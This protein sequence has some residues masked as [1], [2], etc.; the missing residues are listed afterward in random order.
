MWAGGAIQRAWGQSACGQCLKFNHPQH[1]WALV[2]AFVIMSMPKRWENKAITCCLYFRVNLLWSCVLS[3]GLINGCWRE[4][5][6]WPLKRKR[7]TCRSPAVHKCCCSKGIGTISFLLSQKAPQQINRESFPARACT[8]PPQ[9]AIP[10]F[11][12][13]P[14]K[15]SQLICPNKNH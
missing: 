10:K 4:L 5:R 8:K 14:S 13:L 11:L 15:G 9:T 12:Q 3:A 1:P 2:K 6:D 7:W